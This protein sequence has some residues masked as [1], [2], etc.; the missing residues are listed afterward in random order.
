TRVEGFPTSAPGL[1]RPAGR[2][3][4]GVGDVRLVAAAPG[5]YDRDRRF[6]LRGEGLAGPATPLTQTHPKMK[7]VESI[8]VATDLSE[9]SDEILRA[10]AALAALA[11]AKLHVLHAFGFQSLPYSEERL[12]K[13]SFQGRIQEAER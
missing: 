12:P 1:P 2:G 8:L 11:D 5:W 4:P 13:A 10:A 9:T 6:L 7:S 3:K